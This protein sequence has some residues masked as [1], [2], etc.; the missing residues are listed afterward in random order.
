M[1]LSPGAR[2]G[3]YEILSPLGAGG[4][5]EVWKARDTRLDRHVAVKVLP[6]H[7]AKHPESLARFEREA[8]A[9]AALN[10]PNITGIFD[11]GN[12][13]G[14]AYV[15]MELLEGESLRTRLEQGSL[16]P[17]KATEL[18]I[19]LAQGLAAAHEKGVVHRDLKPDNLWITKEGRL[20][21]LDFGL[22]KQLPGMGKGSDSYLPTAAISPGHHTEKGMIL[23]TLGYMSPEQVR[24]ESVDARSDIFSLGVVLFEMLTGRRAFLRDT[25]SDTMAAILRDEPQEIEGASRPIPPGLK[26]IV[27]HCLEKVPEARFQSARDMVFDLEHVAESPGPQRAVFRGSRGLAGA[28]T[29]AA[30]LAIGLLGLGFWLGQGRKP[31]LPTFTQLSLGDDAVEAARF[32]RSGTSV[33]YATFSRD[34]NRKFKSIHLVEPG[35]PVIHD[36]LG[37]DA[38]L[39]S[40]GPTGE[41]AVLTRNTRNMRLDVP[42]G[43]LGRC[44]PGGSLPKLMDPDIVDADWGPGNQLAVVRRIGGSGGSWFGCRLEFPVGHELLV[45]PNGW[46]RHPRFSPDGRHLAVERHP[47]ESDDLGTVAVVDLAS[48]AVKTLTPTYSTLRGLAWHPKTGEIWFTATNIG[49]HQNLFAVSLGGKVRSLYQAPVGLC[50]H[51]IA[52]DG[53][54]L[55]CSDAREAQ[56][57][58]RKA[59]DAAA[60]NLSMSSWSLCSDLTQDGKWM[61]VDDESSEG[62]D[63]PVF[64]RPTDGSLPTPLGRCGYR[65]ALFSPD[66]QR[67]FLWRREGTRWKPSVIRL[68]G[69]EETWPIGD[70]ELSEAPVFAWLGNE[71]VGFWAK[72]RSGEARLWRLDG[73]GPSPLNVQLPPELVGAISV[74]ST[75]VNL[76]YLRTAKGFYLTDLHK[77][78]EAPRLCPG[79]TRADRILGFLQDGLNVYVRNNETGTTSTLD[80]RTGV[81][82]PFVWQSE[83]GE[84]LTLTKDGKTLVSEDYPVLSSLYLVEGLK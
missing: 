55:L 2:L 9:V 62:P 39:L 78:G 84:P 28:A 56:V 8:K 15:A 44:P 21:I 77:P 36:L 66:N 12:T 79:I 19:Q 13:D 60:R 70:L 73:N 42:L 71:A 75:A 69:G 47:D 68:N 4:M 58:V 14:T 61:L 83:L 33:V 7:L 65:G 40:A 53:R 30:L 26:R 59:G 38:F 46:M 35:N 5:G 27:D 6:D 57:W 48:G 64:L 81:R 22:A 51:D 67:V 37:P 11:L 24:G 17:K 18:A 52:A 32:L 23:G 34:T 43:T 80:L 20:K 54:V 31:P 16:T 50:V 3:P 45:E 49:V 63:Y 82:M 76:I 29:A 41:L 10:H 74:P 1:T 72:A 25:A